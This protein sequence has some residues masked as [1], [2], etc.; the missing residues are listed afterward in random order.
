M[1]GIGASAGGVNACRSFFEQVPADSGMAFVT[2]LH[3]SPEYDSHLSEVLQRSSKIP[4]TTVQDRVQVE[5]NHVYVVS[6]RQSLTMDDGWLVQSPATRMEERRAPIDIF[7]R[8]LAEARGERAVCIVL[9]GTGADGSMGLKRI[10]ERGGTCLVQDPVEAEH[11]DMPRNAVRT[12]LADDVLPVAAMPGRLIAFRDRMQTVRLPEAPQHRDAPDERALHQVFTEL[13]IRTGHDFS[14]YKRGTV[15]RRVER[16]LG[17][18]QVPDLATY[19]EFIREHP[20]EAQALLKDLL[21]SVTQFFRDDAAFKALAQQVVP[22]LFEGKSANDQVRVWVPGCATGEEAYSLA[23]LLSEHAAAI[24]EAPNAQIFATDI[25]EQAVA[26]AREGRYTINDAVDVSPERLQ[27]FFSREGEFYRVRKDLREMVLFAHHNLVKDPP[28]S[29]LDLVSCRNLLI[30]LNHTAQERV[31][32]VLHF[33]LNPQRLPVCRLVRIGGG[34]ERPVRGREQGRA[35]LPESRWGHAAWPAGSAADLLPW[36]ATA[37]CA[38]AAARG[39]RARTPDPTRPAPAAA[40]GV[41]AAVDRRQRRVRD[42]AR[43]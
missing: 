27:R 28:F 39:P 10:K 12:A 9:S 40:G 25:D 13:R 37:A 41:R 38:R 43:V 42:R 3:L 22:K 36:H 17:V 32:E 26:L 31:M 19:A 1:V 34:F 24:S 20:E 8:T 29:H 7:F 23:M 11:D 16:R 35:H 4:V 18:R 14:N 5:P 15:L 6:P 30:Y 33:A 2:I 21:I